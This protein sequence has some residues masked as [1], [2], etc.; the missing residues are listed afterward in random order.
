MLIEKTGVRFSLQYI[1]EKNL[2]SLAYAAGKT[3]MTV[4][5]IAAAIEK[6]I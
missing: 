6:D 5:E 3:T 2:N 1:S 4:R